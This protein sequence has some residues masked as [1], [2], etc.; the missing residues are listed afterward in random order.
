M[1]ASVQSSSVIGVSGTAVGVEVH[2]SNGLPGLTVVG[3][4]DA[5][6]REARDRVRAAILSSK[7]EWPLQRI[8][9]NLAP[10]GVRKSGAGL[11]VAIALGVL[12]AS[13]QLT[14]ACMADTAFI[15]ELGLDG[16]IRSVPGLVPMLSVLQ[17][18]RAVVPAAGLGEALVAAPDARGVRHLRE[19]VEALEG[20]APWPAPD[21]IPV[22]VADADRI[23]L[24]EIR[25]QPWA[26]RALEVAAAGGHHL[27]MFGPPGSGKT[28]LAERLPTLLAP[29][30]GPLA[31]EVTAVHSAAGERAGRPGL[32]R[33]PPFR[34]PHHSASAIAL[35]GGGSHQLRPG[36]VSLAHGGVLFLD[37]LGEFPATVL[38]ALR[39]PLE[40]GCVRISRAHASATLPARFQ[41]IAAM[42]PCPCGFAGYGRCRCTFASV[43]RYTRRVSGPLLDRFDLRISVEPP[44]AIELFGAESAESSEVIAERIASVRRRAVTR[45]VRANNELSASAVERHSELVGS[46]RELLADAVSSGRLSARGVRRVRTVALTIDDLAGG[47]GRLGPD[48][49]AEAMQMRA[50]VVPLYPTM[51]A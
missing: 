51:T 23:D 20:R 29:L 24:S 15:G 45:G 33:R 49:V 13:E 48:R 50:D 35:I 17:A 43:S 31:L 11:D 12:A 19:L 46:A 36:E 40:D 18:T 28:M 41:L 9:V 10:S 38:D 8:T 2:V 37:E 4:P 30:E 14:P 3:L 1:L 47:D 7:F 5:A 26:R 21:P 22:P 16:S 44:S 34:H 42:N 25:G 32:V 6:C 39:Q 27:L